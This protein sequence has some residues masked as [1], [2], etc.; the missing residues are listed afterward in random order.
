M[1]VP[2]WVALAVLSTGLVLSYYSFKSLN[3]QLI[4]ATVVPVEDADHKGKHLDP[5]AE[6]EDPT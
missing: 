4:E 1:A 6:E 5:E 2:N 3:D